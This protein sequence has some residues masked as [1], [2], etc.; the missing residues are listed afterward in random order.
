MAGNRTID[1]FF[2][3]VFAFTLTV[4][5]LVAADSLV[6]FGAAWLAMGLVMASLIGHVEGWPQA[7]AAASLARRYFLAS[8]ALLAVGLGTLWWLTGAATV[9]GVAS[10]V[11]TTAST[12]VLVAAGALL[13]AAMVQSA[14]V[15]FH[16]WLLSSMTAPTPASALMHAGF[17]NAGGILLVRFAPV[18][19]VDAGFML[20]IVLAGTA[21]ALAGKLLKTVQTDVKG[22]LGCSTVGQMGFMIVQAGLGFFGAAITHLILHGFYKAY[23][24]LGSGGRVERVSPKG[25]TENGST[26]LVGV[27]VIVVTGLAGGVLFAG[28]TG[29]GTALDSGL[30][31]TL[32]VVLTVLHA[33]R[34]AVT[35]VSVP[36]T[37]RYGAVPLLALPAIAVYAAVYGAIEGLLSGLPAV[38]EPA[39]L[40]AVHG[41]VVAAFVVAYL[42]IESGVYRRSQRLYVALL[43]AARPAGD[44]LLTTTEDYHEY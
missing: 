33:A 6:L 31:L 16:T 17:V 3:R 39:E 30:V 5:V 4:M 1:R 38:G 34:E 32:L 28:L 42:A 2:G 7:R 35:S 14:L 19:T 12:A 13:L 29:K 9:S 43:N 25:T 10:T 21:S 37:F 23:Q 41:L 40:T 27:A 36:A 44:T 20:A 22:Q 26:G 24:F 15:P 8:S 11:G 18:V